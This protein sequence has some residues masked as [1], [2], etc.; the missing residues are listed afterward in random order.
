MSLEVTHCEYFATSPQ[1]KCSYPKCIFAQ[2][3]L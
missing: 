2:S 1:L 3:F